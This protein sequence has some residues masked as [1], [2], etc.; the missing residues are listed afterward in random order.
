MKTILEMSEIVSGISRKI[1]KQLTYDRYC[2]P[3]P[4]RD[5]ITKNNRSA[6]TSRR[7]F[8]DSDGRS[9][10]AGFAVGIYRR[11]C[12]VELAHIYWSRKDFE[13]QWGLRLAADCYF[14]RCHSSSPMIDPSC[15]CL[16]CKW[17]ENICRWKQFWGE[18]LIRRQLHEGQD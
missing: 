13:N 18:M 11:G 9:S 1:S 7:A 15:R 3:C 10:A 17:T 12:Q 2:I 16:D 8:L 14:H 5:L 4:V 6:M